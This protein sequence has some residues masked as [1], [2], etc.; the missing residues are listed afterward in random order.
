MR[1]GGAPGAPEEPGCLGEARRLAR[2][3]PQ[4]CRRHQHR[5]VRAALARSRL[6]GAL[7]VMWTA[8]HGGTASLA[9]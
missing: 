3:R 5:E 9:K 4:A 1:V 7:A 8:A 2:T 6:A